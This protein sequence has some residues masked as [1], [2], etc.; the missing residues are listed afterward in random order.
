MELQKTLSGAICVK[1]CATLP[2]VVRAYTLQPREAYVGGRAKSCRDLAT[3][4]TYDMLQTVKSNKRHAS[5]RFIV[6]R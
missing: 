4:H 6:L 2:E 1:R 3:V 5:R